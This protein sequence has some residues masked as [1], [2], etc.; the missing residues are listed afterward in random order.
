MTLR[1]KLPISKRAAIARINRYYQREDS[2]YRLKT[3]RGQRWRN[4]LGDH[5]IL[6][7]YR[8]WII[9]KHIDVEELA[10]E[11]EVL[12]AWETVADAEEVEDA[13]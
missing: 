9:E 7:I 11:L 5:Y 4:D 6:D 3:T 2:G 13:A 1:E 12:A 8:N 10:R